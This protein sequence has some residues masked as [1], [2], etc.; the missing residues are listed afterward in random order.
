M[1]RHGLRPNE[2]GRP[3]EEIKRPFWR[4]LPQVATKAGAGEAE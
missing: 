4:V 1:I 2:S 3:L